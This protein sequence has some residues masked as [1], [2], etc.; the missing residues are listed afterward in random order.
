MTG[1]VFQLL[2]LAVVLG[3][4]PLVT[5]LVRKLKARAVGRVGASPL[6]PYRDLLRLLRKQPIVTD[7]ASPLFTAAPAASLSKN[8]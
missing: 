3:V 4:A 5:G 6:Q 2:Q 8:V 1:A 7:S